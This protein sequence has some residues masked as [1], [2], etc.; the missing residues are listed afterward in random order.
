MRRRTLDR[1][2]R[3][4]SEGHGP[5]VPRDVVEL[6]RAALETA[7]SHQRG[8]WSGASLWTTTGRWLAIDDSR[9]VHLCD[10]DSCPDLEAFLA[11]T[12]NVPGALFGTGGRSGPE[13]GIW[14]MQRQGTWSVL[15]E[16]ATDAGVWEETAEL[17]CSMVLETEL[18]IT[19]LRL[20]T[21]QHHLLVVTSGHGLHVAL[22]KPCRP[23]L[24][25]AAI[26]RASSGSRAGS[27][28]SRSVLSRREEGPTLSVP[29]VGASETAGSRPPAADPQKGAGVHAA[30]SGGGALSELQWELVVESDTREDMSPADAPFSAACRWE[31]VGAWIERSV[32]AIGDHTGPRVASNYWRQALGVA[33]LDRHVRVSASGAVQVHDAQACV[34]P[35]Q[36]PHLDGALE[37]VV[38]RGRRVIPSFEDLV[39]GPLPPAPWSACDPGGES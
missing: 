18:D 31:E 38:S 29:A 32:A 1:L 15:R 20:L 4:V 16:P 19:E 30:A 10:G 34:D 21:P 14:E 27:S 36:M 33:Q 13:A 25:R 8:P 9:H 3:V 5:D 35:T 37:Q 26:R 7:A 12:V 28:V 24:L 2:G 11:S 23:L 22:G 39:L 17:L 6:L